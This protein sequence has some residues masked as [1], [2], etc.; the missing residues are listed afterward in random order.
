MAMVNHKCNVPTY[1]KEYLWQS[2]MP[3]MGGAES[4]E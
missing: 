2:I 1:S 4:Y 3:D